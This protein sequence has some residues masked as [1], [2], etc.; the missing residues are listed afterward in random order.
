MKPLLS[1]AL[2]TTFSL[3]VSNLFSPG[4]CAPEE[5]ASASSLE[6]A[7]LKSQLN[8]AKA[9]LKAFKEKCRLSDETF[10]AQYERAWQLVNQN[11]LYQDRLKSF[12][13]EW[14]HKY[15]SKLHNVSDVEKACAGMMDS[16]GDEYSFFRDTGLTGERKTEAGAR[17]VITAKSYKHGVGYIKISTFSARACVDETRAALRQI[18]PVRRLVVDLR[19]NWGGSVD[20]AF[21]IFQMFVAKGNFVKMIG[22]E[23]S[24]AYTESL[25]VEPSQ[26]ER[27]RDGLMCSLSRETCLAP[28]VPLI[29][30]INNES[31]S[32]AEMLAGALKDNGRAVL[33]GGKTF[34]KGV[35]QQVWEFDNG[36]SI[37]ITSARFYRPSGAGI[38]SVGI[39]PDYAIANTNALAHQK[40][41]LQLQK[42]LLMAEGNH[43]PQVAY[44][45]IKLKRSK[46]NQNQQFRASYP[47]RRA[48][49]GSR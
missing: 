48:A 39:A 36:T 18:G 45:K 49:F 41:D 33:I 44:E 2:A 29:I 43:T 11:F 31:K 12:D 19:D 9:T 37:K 23:D 13:S 35:V 7:K 32:A 5:Q 27:W 28:N 20:D 24:L 1:L 21:S 46:Q 4:A 40:T 34:G 14:R 25:S 3:F 26:A 10:E 42:A 17:N 6:V 8:D 15:Q 30:L 16:L 22:R 38:H 47:V